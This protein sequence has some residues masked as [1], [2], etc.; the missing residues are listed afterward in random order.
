MTASRLDEDPLAGSV[1]RTLRILGRSSEGDNVTVLASSSSTGQLV[2]VKLISRGFDSP[3]AKYLLRELLNHYELTLAKHPH[4]V[5][6]V[7]CG[8]TLCTGTSLNAG[9][10]GT[11]AEAREVWRQLAREIGATRQLGMAK[12]LQH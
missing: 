11:A 2:A 4:V 6:Y 1:L 7:V 8:Q 3:R 9:R 5:R 12:T 10:V